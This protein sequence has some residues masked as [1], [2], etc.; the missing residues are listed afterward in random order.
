MIMGMHTIVKNVSNRFRQMS[1]VILTVVAA[2]LFSACNKDSLFII[3][4]KDGDD[5]A[6]S[7]GTS[8]VRV[9]GTRTAYAGFENISD[10]KEPIYWQEGDLVRIC[11]DQVS[12]P[13][14]KYADYKVTEV[15]EE[16]NSEADIELGDNN[17]IGLRWNAD[18]TKAH[19]FYAAYPSPYSEGICT[20]ISGKALTANLPSSQNTLADALSG[21][22]GR[23]TLYP[24][25]KWQL[26]TAG[27]TSYKQSEFPATGTVFLTFKAMT[28]AIQFTIINSMADDLV[29]KKA[30][31]QSAGNQISGAFSINDIGDLA[32]DNYPKVTGSGSSPLTAIEKTDTLSMESPITLAQN[33][34]LTF[35]FFLAPVSSV[36]D[37]TLRL[38]RG[39]DAWASLRL[40]YTSGKG[41]NFQRCKKSFVTANY[42]SP[43]SVVLITVNNMD[44]KPVGEDQEIDT[45]EVLSFATALSEW[46]TEDKGHIS[47]TD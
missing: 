15:N 33:D 27:P 17:A 5:V 19:T 46:K 16:D 14:S 32:S 43:G 47:Y 22:G 9:R 20:E 1:G 34:S 2:V 3:S 18:A 4:V 29:I 11:C 31:L 41:L 28:T 26:M 7:A 38:L 10:N 13:T 23:D 39:D 35:T 30:V 12:E 21:N 25:M 36:D 8:G 44:W 6:F 42:T 37:L 24:D 45:G 40:G